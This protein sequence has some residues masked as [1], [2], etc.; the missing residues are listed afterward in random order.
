MPVGDETRIEVRGFALPTAPVRVVVPLVP[1]VKIKA[2]GVG[3]STVLKNLIPL[4]EEVVT[5]T[6]AI[7]SIG[8]ETETAPTGVVLP[9]F[10]PKLTDCAEASG[11]VRGKVPL[12]VLAKSMMALGPLASIE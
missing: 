11:I 9:M 6:F 8:T 10:P 2:K 1:G 4:P 7:K 12:I 5:A 3:L